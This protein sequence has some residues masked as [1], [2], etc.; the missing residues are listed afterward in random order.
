MRA[1][2]HVAI[3]VWGIVR[4]VPSI[5]SLPSPVKAAFLSLM[6][7]LFLNLNLYKAPLKE[8][9]NELKHPKGGIK[10]VYVD[11][12][13]LWRSLDGSFWSNTNGPFWWAMK[14][15]KFNKHIEGKRVVFRTVQT[16]VDRARA[17]CWN[18]NSLGSGEQSGRNL[19]PSIFTSSKFFCFFLIFILLIAASCMFIYSLHKDHVLRFTFSQSSLAHSNAHASRSFGSVA[20][21]LTSSFYFQWLWPHFKFRTTSSI[22]KH[23]KL[24][25]SI[26][27]YLIHFKLCIVFNRG[28]VQSYAALLTLAMFRR[29]T[30]KYSVHKGNNICFRFFL[31]AVSANFL[32]FIIYVEFYLSIP[33]WMTFTLFKSHG[34][35]ERLETTT[36]KQKQTTTTTTTTK[37]KKK[38]SKQTKKQ[39]LTQT[40]SFSP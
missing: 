14:G 16:H 23:S 15:Q 22:C 32:M 40:K 39:T 33:F 36:N 11:A 4:G 26:N 6:T 31:D 27:S 10:L 18:E 1:C 28:L 17:V 12:I 3:V 7:V 19:Q 5:I 35:L 37:K 34:T 21:C 13:T 8:N 2:H 24:C 29:Q 30:D 25:I 20:V 9:D 38:R